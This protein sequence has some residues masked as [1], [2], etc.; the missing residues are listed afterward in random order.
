MATRKLANQLM[1][2]ATDIAA[3]R[4]PCENNSVEVIHGTEAGPMAKNATQTM[5]EPTENIQIHGANS[6][7]QKSFN[8][9]LICQILLSSLRDRLKAGVE[10]SFSHTCSINKP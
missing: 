10:Q 8:F 3:G 7:W 1:K 9:E 6:W 5:V 4:A 2:T